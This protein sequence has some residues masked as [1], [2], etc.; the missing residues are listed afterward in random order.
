MR[1]AMNAILYLLRSGFL[2]L[3]A[4]R[5]LSASLDCL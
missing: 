4:P 1:A 3:S 5:P 2:A